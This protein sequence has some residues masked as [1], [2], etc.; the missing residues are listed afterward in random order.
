MFYKIGSNNFVPS[1]FLKFVFG[2]GVINFPPMGFNKIIFSKIY[3]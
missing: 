2:I 3:I 1:H